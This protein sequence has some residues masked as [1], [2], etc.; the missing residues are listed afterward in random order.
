MKLVIKSLTALALSATIASATGNSNSGTGGDALL[1]GDAINQQNNHYAATESHADT[2]HTETINQNTS[3]KQSVNTN[4][5]SA[6]VVSNLTT[7]G[8]DTCFG[9]V[10]AG[11]AGG[12]FGLSSGKTYVDQNCVLMKQSKLLA[13]LG[14]KDAAVLLLINADP[15]LKTAIIGAYPDLAEHL[16]AVAADWVNPDAN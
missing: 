10:T 2:T 5:A 9:S 15:A 14:L 12:G 11:I 13:S 4:Q 16:G 7:S 8:N 6:A 3:H 1:G